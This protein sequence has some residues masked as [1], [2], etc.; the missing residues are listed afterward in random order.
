[1][2]P[3]GGVEPE[4]EASPDARSRAGGQVHGRS[5]FR[6]GPSAASAGSAGQARERAEPGAARSSPSDKV[7]RKPDF[8]FRLGESR[9]E[10]DCIVTG[11]DYRFYSVWKLPGGQGDVRGVHFGPSTS[12]WYGLIRFASQ[13]RYLSG[14]DRL[15]RSPT[16]R[17]AIEV[18]DE[19]RDR[20]EAPEELRLFRWP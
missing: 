5:S 2:Y 13:G 10:I 18:Y 14:R 17:E 19:E 20:H 3:V 6:P 8:V 16:L 4:R 7:A 11:R 12:A 1:M 15:R 9:S